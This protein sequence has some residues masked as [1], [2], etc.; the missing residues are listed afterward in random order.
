MFK[1]GILT[2]LYI[3]KYFE[4]I[5]EYEECDKIIKS[6]K[7]AENLIDEKLFTKINNDTIN[8]VIEEYK[9]K[10]LTGKYAVEN[11]KYMAKILINE[12]YGK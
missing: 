6:I 8:I 2:V 1:Y 9:K 3:L 5:E 7:H 12:I 10:N 4:S 11:S